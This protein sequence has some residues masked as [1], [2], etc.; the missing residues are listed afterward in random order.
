MKNKIKKIGIVASL[1]SLVIGFLI[2]FFTNERY[3]KGGLFFIA[4]GIGGL[5][6]LF[7]KNLVILTILRIILI[8]LFISVLFYIYIR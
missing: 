3:S 2:M 7:I 8:S 6:N 4:I 5:L 1:L